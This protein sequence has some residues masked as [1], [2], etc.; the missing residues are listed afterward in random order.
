MVVYKSINIYIF[1][2][3]RFQVAFIQLLD[4]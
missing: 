3:S 4:G 1:Y 2:W